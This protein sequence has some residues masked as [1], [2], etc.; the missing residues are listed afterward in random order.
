MARIWKWSVVVFLIIGLCCHQ[1]EAMMN[2]L[3]DT[4]YMVWDLFF[5]V[6][7]SACL[8]GGFLNVIQKTGFMNYFS[9]LLKPLFYLIY[10]PVIKNKVIYTY[11]SSNILAN[12]LGLG[13]LATIS[14]V[15]AFQKLQELNHH[16]KCPSRPMLTLVIINTAGLSLFLSTLLMIR[17]QMGSQDI[18]AF[19]P[20]MLLI[21]ITIIMIGLIM[22]R[23]I[24]HE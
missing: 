16:S 19:Y 2:A 3:M 23:V 6:I 12:L 18:Y 5:N 15:K 8:W 21:G 22:Q 20:Y 1:E 24:D 14:G 10:G 11:L 9:F 7:L 17:Q 13:T 4:P